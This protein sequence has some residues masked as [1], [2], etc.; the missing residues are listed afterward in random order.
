[1][2]LIIMYRCFMSL[3]TQEVLL[4]LFVTRC[5]ILFFG[6][7]DDLNS[8]EE[9][10][11]FLKNNQPDFETYLKERDMNNKRNEM[12]QIFGDLMSEVISEDRNNKLNK[13]GI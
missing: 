7:V 11:S 12:K 8:Q 1:M 5:L 2:V 9:W 10:I 3:R 6:Q 4:I 13:L